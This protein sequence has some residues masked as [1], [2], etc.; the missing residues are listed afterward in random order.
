[1]IDNATAQ[2]LAQLEDLLSFSRHADVSVHG[3]TPAAL[4]ELMA[5][6]TLSEISRRS[7]ESDNGAYLV[8][9]FSAGRVT[10]SLFSDDLPSTSSG[11]GE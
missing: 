6:G 1:M 2:G 5:A 8:G 10:F 11:A 3:F 4:G 7:R 9:K